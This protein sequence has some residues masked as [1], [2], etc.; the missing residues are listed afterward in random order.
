MEQRLE[1]WIA[2]DRVHHETRAKEQLLE[3][4]RL[5]ES[6]NPSN[7]VCSVLP[8]LESGFIQAVKEKYAE[9]LAKGDGAEPGEAQVEFE[10]LVPMEGHDGGVLVTG[11]DLIARVAHFVRTKAA[12]CARRV[13]EQYAEPLIQHLTEQAA[14]A[15]SEL[16]QKKMELQSQWSSKTKADV[17]AVNT[18]FQMKLAQEK[19]QQQQ[20][21][22]Q[23]QQHQQ[24]HELFNLPNL[25]P[26][27]VAAGAMEG[28]DEALLPILPA[29][30]SQVELV[31]LKPDNELLY[32]LCE[33]EYFLEHLRA[34]HGRQLMIHEQLQADYRR[35]VE[36]RQQE[37]GQQ[38]Q[39][40]NAGPFRC[41][42]SSPTGQFSL[43]RSRT[44]TQTLYL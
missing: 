16:L 38:Q 3:A 42:G 18:L 14:Q 15:R 41:M 44:Q 29:A 8:E 11:H 7:C 10:A 24:A 12:H 23:L 40:N 19:Q 43:C 17:Q 28:V 1:Q 2:E 26:D 22:R 5:E 21:Q 39:P 6:H 30:D 37:I 34:E 27:D 36:A 4:S 33:M 13:H 32:M 35:M 20:Q 31:A 9:L 25:E